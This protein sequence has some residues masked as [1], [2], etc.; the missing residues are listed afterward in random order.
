M[1]RLGQISQPV[2]S[3]TLLSFETI[4]S[5]TVTNKKTRAYKHRRTFRAVACA[6]GEAVAAGAKGAKGDAGS[7][8]RP[9]TG[10]GVSSGGPSTG[11]GV[12]SPTVGAIKQEE[13]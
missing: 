8:P 7:P 5:L 11:A 9:S 13:C 3:R 12:S 10:A 6:T 1:D 4:M 2:P